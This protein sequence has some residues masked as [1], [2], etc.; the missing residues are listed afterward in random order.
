MILHSSV[1]FEN[2]YVYL[3]SLYNNQNRYTWNL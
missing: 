2:T 3:R 1:R